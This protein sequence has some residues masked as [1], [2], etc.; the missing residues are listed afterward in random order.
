[1]GN[2]I[3]ELSLG[4]C[5]NFEEVNLVKNMQK[6]KGEDGNAHNEKS[7]FEEESTKE[8]GLNGKEKLDLFRKRKNNIDE[9]EIID[10]TK[11]K[12]LVKNFKNKRKKFI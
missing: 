12:E 3:N 2:E 5:N 9:T 7:Y 4:L 1:M 8:V 10:K 6:E 11:I